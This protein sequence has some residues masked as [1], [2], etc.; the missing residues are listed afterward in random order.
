MAGLI[1]AGPG[2]V[3]APAGVADIAPASMIAPAV[4]AARKSLRI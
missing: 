2:N 1:P 3:T 4:A